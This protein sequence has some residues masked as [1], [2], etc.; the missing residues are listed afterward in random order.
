MGAVGDRKAKNLGRNTEPLV[1]QE[2]QMREMS[3]EKITGNIN[4]F[5]PKIHGGRRRIFG[6]L[7]AYVDGLIVR[8]NRID[9][10]F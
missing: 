3:Q 8:P 5:C 2:K 1:W 7:P 6:I 10:D 4:D 9:V